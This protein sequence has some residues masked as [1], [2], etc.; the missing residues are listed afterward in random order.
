MAKIDDLKTSILD[1]PSDEALR[2]MKDIRN[3]R[4]QSLPPKVKK[5]KKAKKVKSKKVDAK[6][7]FKSL[8]IEQQLELLL[9]MKKDKKET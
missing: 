1:M 4:R 6:T 5:A 2:L 3:L 8:P 7:V 9:K